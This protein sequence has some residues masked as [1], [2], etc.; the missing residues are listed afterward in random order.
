MAE[1]HTHE[2]AETTAADGERTRTEAGTEKDDT[3]ES[4][5]E[6]EAGPRQLQPDGR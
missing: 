6:R 1:E 4:R 3:R 2:V 5:V